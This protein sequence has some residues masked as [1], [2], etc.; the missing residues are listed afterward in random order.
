MPPPP[1]ISVLAT[2]ISQ[3]SFL[4]LALGIVDRFV[5]RPYEVHNLP[6]WVTVV[7]CLLSP[8]I[9][10]SIQLLS[11]DLIVYVKAKR[12]G[13]ILPPHNPSWVPGAIH[14]VFGTMKA[15]ETAYLGNLSAGPCDRSKTDPPS[16]VTSLWTL[17]KSLGIPSTREACSQIVSAFPSSTRT[18][19]SPNF[20]VFPY[21]SLQRSRS[22]SKSVCSYRFSAA[23]ADLNDVSLFLRPTLITMRKV[24]AVV[25]A[26][27]R[28]VVNQP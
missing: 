6:A 15:E 22:I 19:N 7:T 2:T 24:R 1:G 13:A 27:Y 28:K 17:P 20:S 5:L 4:P 16:K 18:F 26:P 10:F 23:S 9:A 14:R 21:R 3:A 12:A 11:G 25:S 8:L